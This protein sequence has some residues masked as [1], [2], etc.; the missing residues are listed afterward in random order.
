MTA[1]ARVGEAGGPYD[2]GDLATT[3]EELANSHLDLGSVLVPV[4][5]GGQVSVEMSVE[6]EPEAV[7][8][9]TPVGRVSVAANKSKKRLL[10]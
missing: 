7:Y 2:I 8:L 4:V 10:R 1:T 3:S 5:E 6:H 9:L